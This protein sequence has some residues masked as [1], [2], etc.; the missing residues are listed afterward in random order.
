[1]RFFTQEDHAAMGYGDGEDLV[2]IDKHDAE[3]R[4]IELLDLLNQAGLT[5]RHAHEFHVAYLQEVESYE[6]TLK[7][8]S[9]S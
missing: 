7:A 4:M 6:T 9:A 1:M 8:L 5:E 3:R 2:L